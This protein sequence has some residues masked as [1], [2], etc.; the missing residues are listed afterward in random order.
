MGEPCHGYA[1]APRPGTGG[2]LA[3]PPRFRH[4]L[5]RTGVALRGDNGPLSVAGYFRMVS[6]PGSP[7]V[8][9]DV[10][11]RVSHCHPRA[12]AGPP[13]YSSGSRVFMK[14]ADNIT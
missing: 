10:V 2:L 7:V 6:P 12:A 8:F 1:E 4:R 14:F 13:D 3:V 5:I 11:P 9:V